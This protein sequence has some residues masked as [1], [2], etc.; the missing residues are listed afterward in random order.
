LKELLENIGLAATLFYS[1]GPFAK[2]PT[3]S[4]FILTDQIPIAVSKA[5]D[6]FLEKRFTSADPGTFDPLTGRVQNA[7]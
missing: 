1:D 7:V 5:V 6:L 2:L 3:P 4:L